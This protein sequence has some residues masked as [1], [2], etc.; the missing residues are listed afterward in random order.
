[1]KCKKV[2]VILVYREIAVM[3]KLRYPGII[4][5][6]AVGKSRLWYLVMEYFE[7]SNLHDVLY[8]PNLESKFNL[9]ESKKNFI[10]LEVTRIAFL[11]GYF[12]NILK[13]ITSIF[14]N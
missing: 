9:D 10:G 14:K 2:P 8:K 12:W 4:N 5:L 6:M 11:L 7:S 3:E 1:M 13:R